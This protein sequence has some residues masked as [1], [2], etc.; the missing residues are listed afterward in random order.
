VVA[1]AS[2][3]VALDTGTDYVPRT[4]M[5]MIH[6][7]EAIIPASENIAPYSGGGHTFNI[8][9]SAVDVQSFNAW[10]RNGGGGTMLAKM[11][12]DVLKRNPTLRPSY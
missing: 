11:I 1:A 6:Q 2:A 9:L 8:N 10:L 5:A 4:G 7:G 3:A 12:S